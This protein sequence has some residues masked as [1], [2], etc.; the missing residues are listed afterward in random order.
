MKAIPYKC[1]L[2]IILWLAY[3]FNQGDR[4]I[5]NAVIPLIKK[6]M[7]LSDIEL[8]MIATIFTIVYGCIVPF[9]GYASDFMMR[10][11]IIFFSLLI[12]C[13]GFLLFGFSSG[14]FSLVLIRGIV[15]GG[16]EAFY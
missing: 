4:Q 7:R 6:D 8:G 14:L 12:F 5:F 3:F 16:G 10:K 1:E 11:W 2:I 13:F 9:A 15:T